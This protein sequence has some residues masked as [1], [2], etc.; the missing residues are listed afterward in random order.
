M[1]STTVTY[2][3]TTAVSLGQIQASEVQLGARSAEHYLAARKAKPTSTTAT[4]EEGDAGESTSGSASTTSSKK[5]TATAVKKG[6]NV[7]VEDAEPATTTAVP[8][9]IKNKVHKPKVKVQATGTETATGG[10]ASSVSS[11]STTAWWTPA[12]GE[13]NGQWTGSSA[14]T[15]TW[16]RSFIAESATLEARK[17]KRKQKK[18]AA[19][20][21]FKVS[22]ALTGMAALI[23]GFRVAF[24]CV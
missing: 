15:T 8:K 14:A 21:S 17:Y 7:A 23:F 18:N 24:Q 9:N 11:A 6:K 10:A 2:T 13:N 3:T 19:A 22:S 12:S 4:D 5:G 20:A 1:T 16:K